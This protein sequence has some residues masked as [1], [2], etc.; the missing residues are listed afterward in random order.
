MS[1]T[2]MRFYASTGP[3]PLGGTYGVVHWEHRQLGPYCITRLV[4]H[5]GFQS[6]IESALGIQALPG[7]QS[8]AS[9]L[10]SGFLSAL[11]G[12]GIVPSGSDTVLNVLR[13]LRNMHGEDGTSFDISSG[14]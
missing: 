10:P 5:N 11:S 7:L 12:I 1:H 9:R 2:V 6:S 3:L 4:M 13:A 14:S 8:P